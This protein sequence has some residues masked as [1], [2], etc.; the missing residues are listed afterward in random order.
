MKRL[1]ALTGVLLLLLLPAI[2]QDETDAEGM[3][4]HPL[5]SRMP[6]FYISSGDVK[7]FDSYESPYI[8]GDDQVWEGKLTKIGYSAKTGS[9]SVSMV[10][11][12]RNYENAVKK[13]GGKAIV[14]DPGL[15]QGKITR[16]GATTYVSAQA[17]NDGRDYEL[18]IVECKQMEDEVAVDANALNESIKATG[19]AAVYGIFFDTGKSDIKPES[20]PALT[21]IALLLK[22][23]PKL[24]IYV[25]GHTDY[26]GVLESNLKLSADR[27]AAVVKDLV[28]RGIESSRLKPAGVGPYCPEASNSTD[29][30]KAKNRR[31]E[32]VEQE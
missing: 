1:I 8:S 28:R 4:D 3:Q 13:L 32:L 9:K 15:F 23:N 5:L 25:V 18:I 17:F 24:R 21:Q 11:I 19:K 14:S 2:A 22:Q 16:N 10:Q 27:A 6:G 30:G 20:D 29:E 31:V 12:S 26:T 7:D